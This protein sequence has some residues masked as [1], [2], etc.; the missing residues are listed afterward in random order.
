MMRKCTKQNKNKIYHL[1]FGG[2]GTPPPNDNKIIPKTKMMTKCPKQN[3]K[4]MRKCTKNKIKI[5]FIIEIA[6]F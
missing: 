3:K 2:G 4:M 5:K 1:S 6:L